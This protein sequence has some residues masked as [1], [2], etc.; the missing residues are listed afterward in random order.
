MV[1]IYLLCL[2]SFLL[3]LNGVT[4]ERRGEEGL[5]FVLTQESTR[6]RAVS[7]NVQYFQSIVQEILFKVTNIFVQEHNNKSDSEPSSMC[8]A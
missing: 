4:E 2:K 3:K 8:T 6:E 1:D 7:L 5:C